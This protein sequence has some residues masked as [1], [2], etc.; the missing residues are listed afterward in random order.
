MLIL[1]IDNEDHKEQKHKDETI[2]RPLP[3]V[4]GS[5]YDE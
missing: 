3:L 1:D 4:A 5:K 2:V